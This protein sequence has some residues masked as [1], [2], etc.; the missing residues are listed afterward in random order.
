MA[1]ALNTL[2]ADLYD[3]ATGGGQ[4]SPHVS[5]WSDIV[6]RISGLIGSQSAMLHV[7]DPIA[8]TTSSLGTFN[9]AADIQRDYSAYYFQRDPFVQPFR[10]FQ[11]GELALSQDYMSS[12]EVLASEL[13]SD[14]MRPRLGDG[15]HNAR[16]HSALDQDRLLFIGLQRSRL[17]GPYQREHTSVL[18]VIWPHL[19]RAMRIDERMHAA[20]AGQAMAFDTLDAL[21]GGVLLLEADRRVAFVNRAAERMMGELRASTRDG[22]RLRLPLLREDNQLAVLVAAATRVP[23]P[24]A[25]AMRGSRFADNDPPLALLVTPF[26]PRRR[27]DLDQAPPLALLLISDPLEQPLELA[28]QLVPLFGLTPAEA[29]VAAALASGFSPEEIALTRRVQVVTIRSQVKALMAKTGTRRQG[30]LIRLLLSLPRQASPDP[31]QQIAHRP[32]LP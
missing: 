10:T 13:Y 29:E 19:I 9:I 14:F 18:E 4:G 2:I 30:E 15:F 20:E 17:A 24:S 23:R 6:A 12:R 32:A 31:P 28:T 21:A 5:N 7:V 11:E 8:G 26:Q 25:A 16:I 22:G 3:M 27:Q 1:D